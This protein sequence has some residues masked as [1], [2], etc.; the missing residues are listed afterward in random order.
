M[1]IRTKNCKYCN[2]VNTFKKQK[3]TFAEIVLEQIV[4]II[5][6]LVALLI[7]YKIANMQVSIPSGLIKDFIFLFPIIEISFIIAN[8]VHGFLNK[9]EEIYQLIS[10]DF[11]IVEIYK[12][13]RCN[14]RKIRVKLIRFIIA[15]IRNIIAFIIYLI[16]EVLTN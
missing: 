2:G 10:A 9:D 11:D 15:P 1:S 4:L 14:K 6:T 12:C 3:R 16:A 7:S 5:E 8:L 13:D